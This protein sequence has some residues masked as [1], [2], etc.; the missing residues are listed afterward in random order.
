MLHEETAFFTAGETSF[1]GHIKFVFSDIS[2][3]FIR[4]E[5]EL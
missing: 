1:R 5:F 2:S 3:F 4:I